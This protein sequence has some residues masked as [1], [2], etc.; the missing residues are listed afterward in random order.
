[1]GQGASVGDRQ[2]RSAVAGWLAIALGLAAAVGLLLMGQKVA[3]SVPV[4]G[5]VTGIVV[6]YVAVFAPL[7]LLSALMG[8]V[9]RRPVFRSGSSPGR[10]S[11]LG[12]VSGVAGVAGS[13]GL[14]WLFGSLDGKP[15]APVAGMLVLGIAMTM[16]AVLAEETLF[17]GWLLP[18]LAERSGEWPAVLLSAVAFSLFHLVGG[19]A[20]PMSFVN[21]MLGGLWFALLALRSGGI[22]APLAAHFGWNVAEDLGL[23]LIPNPGV[24]ELGAINDLDMAGPALWGGS[25]EGLNAS[26]AMTLMLVLLIAPLLRAPGKMKA[27][28][29]AASG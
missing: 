14:V 2:R 13:L 8:R 27:F 4:A 25:D 10:W 9:E 6:F 5:L 16:L 24:G 29:Q 23:G 1:M 26:L 3:A 21:L 7:V 20:Q 18:A 12:L 22:L 17:R 28:P 11:V 19:A 15:S